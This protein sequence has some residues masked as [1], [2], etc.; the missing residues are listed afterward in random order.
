LAIQEPDEVFYVAGFLT[1]VS[2]GAD[3][4]SEFGLRHCAQ[5]PQ[6]KGARTA[7]IAKGALNVD[8]GR[9]LREQ[10]AKDDFQPRSGRPPMLGAVMAFEGSVVA[11][12]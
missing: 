8:P 7:E 10:R 11:A 5:A 1:K 9:I 12:N 2:G 6:I 3:E 4:G